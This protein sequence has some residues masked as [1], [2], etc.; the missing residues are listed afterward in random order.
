MNTL[1]KMQKE[2]TPSPLEKKSPY[3]NV[4]DQQYSQIQNEKNKLVY[5]KVSKL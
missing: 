1:L 2:N 5:V 3:K 4:Y